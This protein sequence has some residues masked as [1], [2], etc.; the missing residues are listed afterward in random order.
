MSAQFGP[1]DG[2]AYTPI[3]LEAIWSL[4]IE[5]EDVVRVYENPFAFHRHAA[6]MPINTQKI[7][8]RWATHLIEKAAVAEICNPEPHDPPTWPCT[9]HY[10]DG[11]PKP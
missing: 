2:Y 3:E 10:D 9:I 5:P 6:T 8:D 11:S 7:K 1:M 4:E